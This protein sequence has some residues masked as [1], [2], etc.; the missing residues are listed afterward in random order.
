M[1]TVRPSSASMGAKGIDTLSP[2][3]P[4]ECL[5]ATMPLHFI[6]EPIINTNILIRQGVEGG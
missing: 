4:V 5:S 6:V 2:T 1:G 3:P